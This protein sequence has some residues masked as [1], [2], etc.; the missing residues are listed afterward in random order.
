[1]WKQIKAHPR[2][3]IPTLFLFA[4]AVTILIGGYKLNWAWTGFTGATESY[5][6]LYDWLQLL[7]IPVVLA[8]GG[9]LFTFTISRNE[10]KAADRH[11][12]TERE[13]AQ[14]NQRETALERR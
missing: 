8:L 6:T 14:D 3:T 13:I 4:F 1:M 5:K 2:I 10:R 11:N 12:Q 9:Y 7:I